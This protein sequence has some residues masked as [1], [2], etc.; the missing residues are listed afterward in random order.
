MRRE[1]AGKGKVGISPQRDY[2]VVLAAEL[3]ELVTHSFVDIIGY[4]LFDIT[5]IVKI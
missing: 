3:K 5:K 4:E 1:N 2:D